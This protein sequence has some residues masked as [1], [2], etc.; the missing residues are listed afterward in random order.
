MIA[1]KSSPQVIMWFILFGW[2]MFIAVLAEEHDCACAV[3]PDDA[4]TCLCG[5]PEPTDYYTGI[6]RQKEVDAGETTQLSFFCKDD[7]S[8]VCH[9]DMTAHS[10]EE[11]SDI[12]CAVEHCPS[13]SSSE[14]TEPFVVECT[15][16][17][18]TM[19]HVCVNGFKC[20]NDEQYHGLCE[21]SLSEEEENADGSGLRGRAL[22]GPAG[23]G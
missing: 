5:Y 11:G 8:W 2:S 14:V 3:S 15:N 9:V 7:N 12:A 6:D 19:Q 13:G 1:M 20:S 22:V 18:F 21:V 4:S 23:P 16:T 10:S 17:G